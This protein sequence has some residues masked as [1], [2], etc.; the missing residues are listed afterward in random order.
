MPSFAHPWF[1][2]LLPLVP[3]LV[4]WWLWRRGGALRYPETSLLAR[5]PAGRS[6]LARAAGAAL[7]GLALAC[8]IIALAGPRWPDL[9]T[10]I[11]AEGI[12]IAMVVDVSGSMNERD[13][14][15]Q[16]ERITRLEAVK[17]V[18]RLFV[19]GGEGPGGERLE[20]RS[21]DLIGLIAYDERPEVV[22]PL[23]L[24]HSVLL[25]LLDRLQPRDEATNIG[26]AIAWGLDRLRKAAPQRKVLVLLTDGYHTV[27]NPRAWKPR[28]A[29]NVAVSLPAPVIIY[30]ID[31][32]RESNAVGES[33]ADR[34]AA[35]EVLQDVA[36]RT[37]GKYFPADN[38]QALLAACREIDRLERQEIESFQYRRYHEAYP[39]FGLASFVLWA[40]LCLL[41]TTV[42]RRLP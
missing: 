29:A 7:R 30:T 40:T 20:G 2:L 8:L 9:R 13:F 4:G 16:D 5:L 33:A 23:T 3:P 35:V 34:A 25:G 12:A 10:R 15:W 26:D 6:R 31:A 27:T 38:S 17:K 1:L 22:C 28:Q 21:N 24:S 11:P 41:E 39:W 14:L 19:D 18:F 36:N 32:G 42:W 37:G